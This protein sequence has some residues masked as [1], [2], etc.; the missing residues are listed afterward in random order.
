MGTIIAVIAIVVV[1]IPLKV[2]AGLVN[3]KNGGSR[4][5]RRRRRW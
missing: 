2:I 1:Y 5:G 4:G 3:E